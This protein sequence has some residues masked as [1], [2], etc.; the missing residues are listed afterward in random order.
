MKATMITEFVKFKVLETTN[1][2][3]L[4]SKVD[5]LNEFQQKQDGFIDAEML[6][7]VQ[8]NA[9]CIIYH[10]ESFEKAQVIGEKLRVSKEFDEFN[11]LIFP[12]S[13]DI[14]F[15]HQVSKW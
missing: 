5:I 10:Y 7:G 14:T 9:W 4:I 11:S 12:G 8:G 1:D 6:K 3:Q 15:Y 2:E 13:L